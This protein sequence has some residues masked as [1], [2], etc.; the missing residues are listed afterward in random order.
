MMGAPGPDARRVYTFTMPL[1]GHLHV[2]E[3]YF[4]VPEGLFRLQSSPTSP[5]QYDPW[6]RQ[7]M[8]SRD[9][10]SL[11]LPQRV[12]ISDAMLKRKLWEIG[13]QVLRGKVGSEVDAELAQRLGQ[14]VMQ[15]IHPARELR[16]RGKGLSALEMSRSKH[17]VRAFLHTTPQLELKQKWLE[18]GDSAL[19]KSEGQTSAFGLAVQ[20][21]IGQWGLAA[22]DELLLDSAWFYDAIGDYE[23]AATFL[24]LL[25]VADPLAR[26]A[27]IADFATQVLVTEY[28]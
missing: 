8:A 3:A 23:A 27:G 18:R 16:L 22:I 6:A 13:E 14:R 24:G 26:E 19:I 17:R 2:V 15:P 20:E 21:W 4:C 11:S 12:R 9:E 28:S 5:T 1:D 25:E 10:E 7:M